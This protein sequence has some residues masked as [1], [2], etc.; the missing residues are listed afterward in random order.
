MIMNKRAMEGVDN[1]TLI[2]LVLY[3]SET[4]SRF[5]I[6]AILHLFRLTLP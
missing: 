3:E 1:L 4:T 5:M 2:F 6:L